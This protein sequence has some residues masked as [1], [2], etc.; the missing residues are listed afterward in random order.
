MI[1]HHITQVAVW[2]RESVAFHVR[3]ATTTHSFPLAGFPKHKAQGSDAL[4]PEGWSKHCTYHARDVGRLF[5][6]LVVAPLPGEVGHPRGQLLRLAGSS[7]GG[8][9]GQRAHV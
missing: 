5:Q 6:A 1:G 7:G 2:R 8:R 4:P 3:C 9:E